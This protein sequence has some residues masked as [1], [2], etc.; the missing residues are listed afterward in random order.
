M[1]IFTIKDASICLSQSVAIMIK[2]AWLLRQVA[3]YALGRK[4]FNSRNIKTLFKIYFEV[5]LLSNQPLSLDGYVCPSGSGHTASGA[6][7]CRQKYVSPCWLS[8]TQ[9]ERMFSRSFSGSNAHENMQLPLLHTTEKLE[10]E[11]HFLGG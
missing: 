3:R 8:K 2:S 10:K 6:I 5:F 4:S 9:S 7:S 11:M 1:Y